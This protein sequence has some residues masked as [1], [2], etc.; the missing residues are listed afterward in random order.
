VPWINNL[1]VNREAGKPTHDTRHSR[2]FVPFE[3]RAGGKPKTPLATGMIDHM[4]RDAERLIALCIVLR[5]DPD[6]ARRTDASVD[7]MPA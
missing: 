4:L 6:I 1:D 2:S 7:G 5:N 3:M